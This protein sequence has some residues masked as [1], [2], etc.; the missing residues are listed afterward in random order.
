MATLIEQWQEQSMALVQAALHY[1]NENTYS[2]EADT[3]IRIVRNMVPVLQ[4]AVQMA[5]TVQRPPNAPG[6]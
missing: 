3:N 1:A 6:E 5:S 2:T 4:A